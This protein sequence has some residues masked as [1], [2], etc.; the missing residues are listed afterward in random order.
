MN[1]V[2]V[3]LKEYSNWE[4]LESNGA[5]IDGIFKNIEDAKTQLNKEYQNEIDFFN[6]AN[7]ELYENEKTD[8]NFE[9]DCD[10]GYVS[11]EIQEM[12]IK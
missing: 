7:Q 11:C 6:D 10:K 3:V 8:C 1:K 4:D 2:Y 12:E 5:E 9:I